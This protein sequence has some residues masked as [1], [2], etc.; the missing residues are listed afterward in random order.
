MT[1]HPFEDG[2][3]C[4]ARAI[5]DRALGA[6]PRLDAKGQTF[7]GKAELTL[8]EP[9]DLNLEWA[10]E[11]Y[12]LQ[13]KQHYVELLKWSGNNELVLRAGGPHE[14]KDII[15]ATGRT[16]VWSERFPPLGS[17]RGDLHRASIS[18]VQDAAQ[19]ALDTPLE[20]EG[21]EGRLEFFQSRDLLGI[22]ARTCLE[23]LEWR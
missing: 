18:E 6:E 11:S 7:A 12:C 16:P 19:L 8:E 20:L 3:G 17:S 21:I 5:A 10:G 13:G 4:I 23:P 2:N 14:R 9:A 22:D 1:I 15:M